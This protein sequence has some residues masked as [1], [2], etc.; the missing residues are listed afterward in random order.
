LQ[1]KPDESSKRQLLGKQYLFD[2]SDNI[3]KEI[4]V[5]ASLDVVATIRPG[6]YEVKM[7][8]VSPGVY[9][10][11]VIGV[12]T[13]TQKPY[14]PPS[15]AAALN[16]TK[17]IFLL[18]YAPAGSKKPEEE[19][20][21]KEKPPEKPTPEDVTGPAGEAEKK[22]KPPE[23]GIPPPGKGGE[24]EGGEK[25]GGEKEGGEKKAGGTEAGKEDQGD[26]STGGKTG[27]AKGGTKYGWLE[28]F[29]LPAPLAKFLEGA[30]DLLGDGEEL[31][32]LRDTLQTLRELS[33]HRS[34]LAEMFEDPS[35][36]LE[37]A[38]GLKENAAISAIEAWVDKDVKAPKPAKK[39]SHKGIVG[40][41][42]KILALIR[43]LRK[44]LKPVFKVRKGVHSAL[45]AVGLVIEA[46]PVLEQLL[47]MTKDPSK[48]PEFNLQSAADQLAA[49]FAG[50]LKPRIEK[51]PKQLKEA[52]VRLAEADLVSY[53]ELAR[54]V[55]A[56]ILMGVPKVY[57][58]IVWA[59]R[60]TGLEQAIADNV[61][62]PL[63]PKEALDGVNDVVRSLIKAAEPTFNGAVGD[64]EKIIAELGPGFLEELPK[65][66]LSALK[67]SLKAGR[68]PRRPSPVAIA[69][70][71]DASFGEPLG[72]DV[73]TDAETRLGY[74]FADVR[75][76]RDA[77]AATAS[78]LLHAHAFTVGGDVFF[79]PGKFAPE[80][81]EGRRLLYHELTHTAQ[82]A[83]GGPDV[84]PTYKD[85]L[86]R[87]AKRF[88]AKVIEELKGATTRSPAKLKQIDQIKDRVAKI[89][90]RKVVSRSNPTLPTGYSYIPKAKGKIK[91]IR[92]SL[93]FIRFIPALTIDK[94]RI[95]RLA[96][97][98]ST[99][100]PGNAARAALRAALGCDSTRQQAHHCIP[101][102]LV[103]HTV[104]KTAVKN[105]F[106]FNGADNGVC[107]S[108]RIH[109]G[110]H[111]KYTLDVRTRLNTLLPIGTDWTKL[112]KP[113]R[114]L[115]ATLKTEVKARRKRLD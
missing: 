81:T 40:L 19:T 50:E 94:K 12:G 3:V 89:V 92:R 109:S 35:T 38:L 10:V 82:Q 77:P 7:T 108:N 110:S 8:A 107:I 6:Y 55:T 33:E 63:I 80:S 114:A 49:D 83:A 104:V 99:F 13:F 22:E 36:L 1:R 20:E 69:G 113:F 16:R 84:Q 27:A 18:V 112:E 59:A 106:K 66:V 91:T 48:I 56:A 93:T 28:L 96:A 65:E 32:A 79:G 52:F 75:V 51:A 74:T 71:I 62:A 14:H 95:I 9:R 111:P 17:R 4:D 85:L 67:P 90:G 24:K 34:E 44:M 21:E 47:E 41:A 5:N 57:K 73:R 68:A 58:P 101:L 2:K 30:I 39:T 15:F 105:G 76:H 53:E 37:I 70:L 42:L 72:E 86:T 102:E 60:R 103:L 29:E 100:S 26:L 54:G 78:E 115:V 11:D 64:L 88:S 45:E 25:K 23:A 43:K 98:L 46:L 61:V 87:L 31:L 97:T